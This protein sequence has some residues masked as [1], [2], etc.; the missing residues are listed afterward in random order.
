MKENPETKDRPIFLLPWRLIFLLFAALCVVAI[1]TTAATGPFYIPGAVSGLL[2]GFFG[3]VFGGRVKTICA[4]VSVGLA[5]AVTVAIPAWLSFY[6]L[7]PAFAILAGTELARFGTRVTIFAIMSWITLN[8]PVTFGTEA[9]PL[10]FVFSASAA[11]G[12]IMAVLLGAEGRVEPSEIERGYAI[13]HGIALAIGLVFAQLIASQ[14][15]NAHSHWVAL[16]FTARALDPPGSHVAQARRKGLAMVLG[17]GMASALVALPLTI[18][19]FK[20]V[21]VVFLLIGLRYL[22]SRKSVSPALI[23]AGIVLVSSPTTETASFRA[24]AAMLACGLVLLV[25]F[26]ARIVRQA[27]FEKHGI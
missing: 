12:T 20:L 13:T 1:A 11:V 17:A 5:S 18:L 10:L 2:L 4:V 7:A 23:S 25:F 26:G 8:S 14:F 3:T 22:P 6:V 9:L 24:E 15:E 16:L 19:H 27:I 21:A